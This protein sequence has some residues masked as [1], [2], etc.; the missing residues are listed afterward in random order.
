MPDRQQS[1]RAVWS[2]EP[3]RSITL[4]AS[5]PAVLKVFSG[6]L[7]A[8]GDGQPNHFAEDLVLDEGEELLLQAGEAVVVEGWPS[9][10]FEM[11]LTAPQ[12]RAPRPQL[13]SPG[14]MLRALSEWWN[15]SER[16]RTN[17]SH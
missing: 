3:G 7:W 6:R 17:A 10:R 12:F 14:P 9:A 15:A 16:T 11:A 2:I 4:R 1:A 13:R 8:T 5:E